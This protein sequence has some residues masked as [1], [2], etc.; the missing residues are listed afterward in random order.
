MADATTVASLKAV[1]TA[2]TGSLKKGLHEAKTGLADLKK[3]ADSSKSSLGGMQSSLF[4]MAGAAGIATAALFA[5]RKGFD[6]SR[7][8]AQ[9]EFLE[10]KFDRLSM[11]VG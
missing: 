5:L 3:S 6:F 11:A 8:G 1:I 4:R 2:E 10:G 9:L 7:E